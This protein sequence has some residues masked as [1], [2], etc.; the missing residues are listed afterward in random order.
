MVVPFSLRSNPSTFACLLFARAIVAAVGR[1]FDVGAAA[2]VAAPRLLL[3]TDD[4]PCFGAAVRLNRFAAVFDFALAMKI[5]LGCG[6]QL[7]PPPQ[8]R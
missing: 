3:G 8:P 6:R 1:L 4:L 7:R 5:S 2:V